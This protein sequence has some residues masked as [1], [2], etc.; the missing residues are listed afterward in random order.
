M[1]PLTKVV[2]KSGVAENMNDRHNLETWEMKLA[3]D[4]P[5]LNFGGDGLWNRGWTRNQKSRH[6]SV[7]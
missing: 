6:P 2:Q 1:L 3:K 7:L 4:S 5:A